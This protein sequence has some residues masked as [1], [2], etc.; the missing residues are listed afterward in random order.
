MKVSWHILKQ[1]KVQLIGLLAVFIV[2]NAW[3]MD[4]AAVGPQVLL[5][6]ASA[7]FA[8]WA[9]FGAAA[10]AAVQSA[11]VSGLLVAMIVSPGS[12]HTLIVFATVAALASKKLFLFP[13]G[14]HIFNPAAFGLILSTW[15]FGNQLNWW[16]TP[17]PAWVVLG[18]GFILLRLRR[19]PLAFG[20]FISRALSATVLGTADLGLSAALIPNMF[21]AFVMVVEPKTSPAKPSAQWLFGLL[22][23]VAATAFYQWLPAYDG[24]LLALLALNLLRP[25]VE[26]V[27]GKLRH[28]PS[29]NSSTGTDSAPVGQ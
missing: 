25:A 23:G 13:S 6:M 14:R 21:F 22:C 2:A 19:L 10:S 7:L 4:I 3:S 24:D 20:Y 17:H 27:A 16:G 8:E 18:A 28:R 26:V 5:A 11:L 1:A 9:F 29:L 12:S 15:L